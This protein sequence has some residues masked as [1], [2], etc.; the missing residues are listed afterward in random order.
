MSR[1]S[2]LRE[3]FLVIDAYYGIGVSSGDVWWLY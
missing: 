2:G 1:T 3:R